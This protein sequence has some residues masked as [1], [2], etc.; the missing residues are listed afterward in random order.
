M[1]KID[2]RALLDA[3]LGPL[4]N[5]LRD[6]SLPLHILTENRFG[7]LNDNQLEMIHAAQDAVRA[8]DATLR[9]VSRI[10]EMR[11]SPAV[12]TPDLVRGAEL[13][14]APM[15]AAAAIA[16]ERDII[17]SA[18]VAPDLPHVQVDR[19]AAEEALSILLSAVV[20]SVP[21][22]STLKLVAAS[23]KSAMRLHITPGLD[24]AAAA[25]LMELARLLLA[26][27][28]AS[29]DCSTS[30]LRIDVARATFSR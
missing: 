26:T 16:A 9:L 1:S 12:A 25:L 22:G 10:Y 3:I 17:W 5:R 18:D 23:T 28:A 24:V 29:F 21:A 4:A 19:A 2:D 8:A 30:E 7:E 6:V 20:T 15:S 14:R 11:R 13:L 27:T